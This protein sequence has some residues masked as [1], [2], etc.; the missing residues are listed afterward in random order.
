[1][2]TKA[3][4]PLPLLQATAFFARRRWLAHG[5]T[6]AAQGPARRRRLAG[7]VDRDR[8]VRAVDRFYHQCAD[9]TAG[10]RPRRGHA[11]ERA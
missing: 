6:D 2:A 9:L 4:T 8:G 11:I 1:M 3:A 7:V 10:G 5:G